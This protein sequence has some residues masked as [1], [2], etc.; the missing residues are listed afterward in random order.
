MAADEEALQYFNVV[1]VRPQMQEIAPGLL[2]NAFTLLR[3][4]KEILLV[5]RLYQVVIGIYPVSGSCLRVLGLDHPD[6]GE[7]H[8]HFVIY[9]DAD[10]IVFLSGHFKGIFK[11]QFRAA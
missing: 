3:L 4:V 10:H 2:E 6:P 11:V 9:F 8:I 1:L 5:I 7:L